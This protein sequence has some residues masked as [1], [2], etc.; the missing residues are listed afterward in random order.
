MG[1]VASMRYAEPHLELA[2]VMALGAAVN[3]LHQRSL[4]WRV[5][6]HGYTAQEATV[7][8]QLGPRFGQRAQRRAGEDL[9][10]S[11]S[12]RVMPSGWMMGVTKLY[13]A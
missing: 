12:S 2:T 1:R 9:L 5:A 7:G 3:L 13:L 10:L 11:T 8:G 6:Q 4:R